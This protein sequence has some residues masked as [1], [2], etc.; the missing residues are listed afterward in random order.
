[1]SCGAGGLARTPPGF[2]LVS[3]PNALLPLLFNSV[4]GGAGGQLG[5]GVGGILQITPLAAGDVVERGG[6]AREI[7]P[8]LFH[9]E[10]A[11]ASREHF[12][13]IVRQAFVNPEKI[14]LHNRLIIRS[15]EPGG[16]AKFSVP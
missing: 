4:G 12:A 2:I 6:S 15:R 14:V 8:L 16:A 3:Q 11:A 13:E 7:L 1:M 10:Q 9:G 5:G